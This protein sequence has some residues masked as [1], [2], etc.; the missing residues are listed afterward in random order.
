VRLPHGTRAREIRDL[1]IF[2]VSPVLLGGGVGT[3]T[4]EVRSAY[5]VE[6]V[7]WVRAAHDR[8]TRAGLAAIRDGVLNR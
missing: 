6:L 2:E 7:R 8:R 3:R 5:E 1:A 4:L